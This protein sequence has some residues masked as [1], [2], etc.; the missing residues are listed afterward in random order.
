MCIPFP[1]ILG[2]GNFWIQVKKC[3][4]LCGRKC[5]AMK[6]QKIIFK[7]PQL[8]DKEIITKYLKSENHRNCEFVFSNLYLWSREVYPVEYAIIE[9]TLCFLSK[10][11]K[12]SV[13]FPMGNGDKKKVIELLKSQWEQEGRELSMY[14]VTPEQFQFLE[15]IYGDKVKIQYDRD[16]ADYIYETEKLTNLSG[17][18]YHGKK[19]HINRFLANHEFWAYE[20]IN[21]ENVEECIAMA[22]E[23]GKLNECDTDD[24]KKAELK[25]AMEALDM[26]K[27]L[28]L[29]GGLLRTKEG[30]IG[31]TLGTEASEDTFVVNI[32][33]AFAHIQG[34]YPLLNREFAKAEASSYTYINREEDA[35]V[36]GLRKAK[37]SYHPAFLIEKGNVIFEK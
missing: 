34:A 32:E 8:E 28:D 16:S 18:K 5:K 25:V 15:N 14:L 36:E 10:S 19:N 3:Y 31:F 37:L 29:K 22:K 26:R 11:E 9:D 2:K 1:E 21:D 7:K 30:V 27:E 33:K 4:N 35:G 24:H 17:K 6:K 12:Y 20:S 23:W 13:T